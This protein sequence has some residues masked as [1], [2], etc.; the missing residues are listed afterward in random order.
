MSRIHGVPV[1]LINRIETGRDGFDHPIYEDAPVEVENVLIAPA[2]TQEIITSTD[3][4]GK[5]A[6]YTI[7]IPK[8][9]THDWKDRK[10]QFFGETWQV[11]GLPQTG[12]DALIPLDWNT[13]W[14]VA[15]YE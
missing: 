3:L 4:Y 12:I 10:V 14:Q 1:T 15:R 11:F 5:K 2:S 8:G 6:V 13:K 7:A 9:D